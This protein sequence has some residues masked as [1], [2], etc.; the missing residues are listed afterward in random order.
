[1]DMQMSQG[2][3][4]A[5]PQMSAEPM[6]KYEICIECME[7]GTFGV[8][9]ESGA[10][11]GMEGQ[12]AQEPEGVKQTAQSWSEAMDRANQLYEQEAGGGDIDSAF[13][14]GAE[15]PDMMAKMRGA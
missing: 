1:M 12:G 13:M 2:T 5:A 4:N 6:P 3:P 15:E 7:D 8:Y 14:D 11:E 10:A 9:K